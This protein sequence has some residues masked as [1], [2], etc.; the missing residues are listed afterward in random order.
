MHPHKNEGPT[1]I[2]ISLRIGH[3]VSKRS[4]AGLRVLVLASGLNVSHTSG[5]KILVM[6]PRNIT[7]KFNSMTVTM[8]VYTT[9]CE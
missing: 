9:V 5:W 7:A 2:V 8:S 6:R 4:S 3:G 1:M